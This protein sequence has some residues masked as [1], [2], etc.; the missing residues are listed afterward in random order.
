MLLPTGTPHGSL[1]VF[2]SLKEPSG[3]VE[4]PMIGEPEAGASHG[5]HSGVPGTMGAGV[6]LGM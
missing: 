1:P 5:V 6:A 3:S 4:V 2:T